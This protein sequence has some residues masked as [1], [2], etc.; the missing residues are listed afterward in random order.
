MTTGPARAT[1]GHLAPGAA[2]LP[3]PDP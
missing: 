3:S 2:E 1:P